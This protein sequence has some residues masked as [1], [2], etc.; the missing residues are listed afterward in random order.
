MWIDTLESTQETLSEVGGAFASARKFRKGLIVV[1]AATLALVGYLAA[2][3]FLLAIAS[4]VLG[5]LVW[6]A[7]A[8]KLFREIGHAL[9]SPNG[10]QFVAS[11]YRATDP[12]RVSQSVPWEFARPEPGP[13]P[14]REDED[15]DVLPRAQDGARTQQRVYCPSCWS[16]MSGRSL[17]LAEGR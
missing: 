12:I 16:L 17:G 14:V 5:A 6:H 4:F 2:P 9:E 7:C 11:L 10:T 13:G 8:L 3:Y 1:S 15:F